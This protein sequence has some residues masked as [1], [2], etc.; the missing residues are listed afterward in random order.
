MSK[1]SF[2]RQYIG[3]FYDLVCFRH[4]EMSRDDELMATL[5]EFLK[6]ALGL[7]Y[8][9]KMNQILGMNKR[10]TV[11]AVKG[12]YLEP[13]RTFFCSELVA[14]IYQVLGVL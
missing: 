14:K 4:L 10:G 11:K 13:D 12:K 6:E 2:I 5:E 3:D 1:W 9:L 7:K 8:G